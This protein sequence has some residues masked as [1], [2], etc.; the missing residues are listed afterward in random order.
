MNETHA[1]IKYINNEFIIFDNS[2][3]NGLWRKLHYAEKYE[4]KEGD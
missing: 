4:I 2:S 3:E 1:I